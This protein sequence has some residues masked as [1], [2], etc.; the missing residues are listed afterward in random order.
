MAAVMAPMVAVAECSAGKFLREDSAS[1]EICHEMAETVKNQ[2]G[3]SH[4]TLAAA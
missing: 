4:R 3:T 1:R 2:V